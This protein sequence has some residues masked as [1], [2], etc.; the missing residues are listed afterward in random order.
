MWL[1]CFMTLF[2]SADRQFNYAYLALP[3]LYW[4]WAVK[5][6]AEEKK[7]EEFEVE[8]EGEEVVENTL[9]NELIAQCKDHNI[10]F[11]NFNFAI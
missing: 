8:E 9:L 4:R 10:D 6:D 11:E 1:R 2:S 7:L 5:L 3:Y